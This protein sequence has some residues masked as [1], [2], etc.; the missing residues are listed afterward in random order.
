MKIITITIVVFLIAAAVITAVTLTSQARPRIG[1]ITNIHGIPFPQAEGSIIVTEKLAHADIYLKQPPLAKQL[2]LTITFT[3]HA[4]ALLEV[5]IRE[6]PFWLS[7][8][9]YVLYEKKS[10]TPIASSSITKTVFIPLTDKIVDQDHSV[11]LMFF[12]SSPD[13]K[14]TEDEGIL[15]TTYWQLHDLTTQV[16]FYQ[17]NKAELKDYLKSILSREKP[18]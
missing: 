4:T 14:D 8:P 3:P 11:D 18:L 15:D 1:P 6:N 5:S 9:K 12:A 16:E 17:P 7:Y 2:I 10:D 13:S